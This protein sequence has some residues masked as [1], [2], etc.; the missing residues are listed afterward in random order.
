[1][2]KIYLRFTIGQTMQDTYCINLRVIIWVY[3]YV[4][5][6]EERIRKIQKVTKI[7]VGIM[8]QSDI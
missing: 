3:Y 5:I 8:Y 2:P 6:P 1:M 4:H 7:H